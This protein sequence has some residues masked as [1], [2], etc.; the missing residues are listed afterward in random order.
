MSPEKPTSQSVRQQLLLSACSI[1]LGIVLV[2]LSLSVVQGAGILSRVTVASDSNRDS[3]S[4][5]LSADGR[6]IVFRSD[7]DFLGQGI[8]DDQREMWLYDIETAQ[9][10]R[11][12]TATDRTR[13]IYNSCLNADGTKIVLESD[14]DFWGQGI[15]TWQFEIWLLNT[16]T[17]TFTRITTATDAQRSSSWP[18]LNADGTKVAFVSNIDILNEGIP[19][20][21]FNLWVY[22]T[23]AMTFTRITTSA[24][25]SHQFTAHPSL[26]ADGTKIAFSS[27]AKLTEQDIFNQEIWLYDLPSAKLTRITT[28]TTSSWGSYDPSL[29]ADGTKIAFHSDSD[30]FGEGIQQDEYEIWLY[31]VPTMELTRVTTASHHGRTSAAP[32]LSADGTKIVFYSDSDF[33]NQGIQNDQYE[34]WLYDVVTATFTRITTASGSDRKSAYPTLNAKGTKIAFYS[35]SDFL[36]QN[37]PLLQYE[38][39]MVSEAKYHLHLPVILK[40]TSAQ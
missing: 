26:S 3:N 1:I 16:T 14:N 9:L 34:V 6:K 31:D 10:T 23:V 40:R 30:F 8:P 29:S 17:M 7:S 32:R 21:R 2:G 5:Q 27:N 19:Y 22:D 12:T 20:S 18:C 33:F 28:G 4:P 24:E 39:W 13:Q 15:P 38:V 35:T 11:I 36:H 25:G 37:I